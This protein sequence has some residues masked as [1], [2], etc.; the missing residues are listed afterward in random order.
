MFNPTDFP[1]N[2]LSLANWTTS[3][4]L[5]RHYH[6]WS[7]D[8]SYCRSLGKIWGSVGVTLRYLPSYTIY[9]SLHLSKSR[10]FMVFVKSFIGFLL[11]SYFK[12]WALRLFMAWIRWTNVTEINTGDRTQL[13][14]WTIIRAFAENEIKLVN[15]QRAFL[16]P[17]AMCKSSFFHY[18]E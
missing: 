16:N 15:G 3:F 5:W 17:F 13:A 12:P 4:G 11:W 8:I 14:P 10:C 9:T 1:L 2:V 7:A 18:Y 6:P